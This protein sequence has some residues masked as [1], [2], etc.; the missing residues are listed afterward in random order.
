[1]LIIEAKVS[2]I[3]TSQ[4]E[5]FTLLY[6]KLASI[7]DKGVSSIA[8]KLPDIQ[9]LK[10][11]SESIKSKDE[12]DQSQIPEPPQP[13]PHEQTPASEP[14]PKEEPMADGNLIKISDSAGYRKYFKMLK[15]GIP[16]PAVKIKMNSEGFDSKLLDN[17][18]LL[19]EKTP[20]DD[21]AQ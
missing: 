2:R 1:M 12:A 9:S 4:G 17:P 16:C 10:S 5:S 14:E 19:I 18:D 21:E 8:E 20:E 7:P 6:F 11:E 3:P 15:V 13:P